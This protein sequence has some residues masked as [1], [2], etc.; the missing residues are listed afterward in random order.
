MSGKDY[1]WKGRYG[2]LN[3]VGGEENTG[4]TRWMPGIKK[5]ILRSTN[6]RERKQEVN[7]RGSYRSNGVKYGSCGSEV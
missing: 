5:K 1:R 6:T 7:P 3:Y 4:V 2:A